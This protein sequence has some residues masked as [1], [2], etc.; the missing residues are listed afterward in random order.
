MGLWDAKKGGAIISAR[1]KKKY[2]PRKMWHTYSRNQVLGV[3]YK[4]AAQKGGHT[5]KQ[6]KKRRAETTTERGN[7]VIT[8]AGETETRDETAT[9]HKDP[10]AEPLKRATPPEKDHA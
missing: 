4:K 3:I 9:T 2:G 10:D 1:R 5:I 7:Y 6:T 8:A